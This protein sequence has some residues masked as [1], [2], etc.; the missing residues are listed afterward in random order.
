MRAGFLSSILLACTLWPVERVAAQGAPEPRR[1]Q[2]LNGLKVLLVNRQTDPEV[3]LKL[4]VHS[5]AAFDLAGKEGL[6]ALLGDALFPDPAT[7]QYVKEE[8]GGR[9]EV[10]TDYDALNITLSGRAQEFERLVELLR[11]ALVST[12][13]TPEVVQR[14]REARL[15]IARDVNVAPATVADRAIAARL[16]GGF[17]YGRTTTGTPESL[18]RI[19][20]ADLLL[21]KERFL[22]PNNATLVAVGGVEPARSLRAL[23][24]YLG[25]WRRSDV[26]VPSTFR[27]PDAP[28]ARTL[29][30][31]MAGMPDAEVRLAV[32]GVARSDRDETAARVL[33]VL[34]RERWQKNLAELKG[35]PVFVEHRAYKLPGVFRMGASV[36]SKLAAQALQT[37]RATLAS[38]VAAQPP[39]EEFEVARREV[40]AAVNARAGTT[41]AWADGWLNQE[42]YELHNPDEARNLNSLTPADIQRLAARI[43]RDT[44]VV[45]IATGD[46]AELRAEIARTGEVEILGASA[47]IPTPTTPDAARPTSTPA[48]TPKPLTVPV[49]RP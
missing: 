40:L 13:L 26:E 21:M 16:F 23:R 5:G 27:Q 20:R 46:A 29:I 42:T 12:Q 31:D 7:Y 37:A 43:F 2:L 36:P 10:T 17:P 15:K 28:D 19:E 25:V 22:N 6:M 14:M 45:S 41:E 30:V 32:R 33:A 11:G 8:L 34:V 35:R 3:F 1:E 49:K 4:R 44:P 38:F 18:A 48:P 47:T 9:L 24:Q 39:V